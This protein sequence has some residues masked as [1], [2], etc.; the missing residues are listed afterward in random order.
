MQHFVKLEIAKAE[1]PDNVICTAV[2]D[3][4]RKERAHRF[5][6]TGDRLP[7]ADERIEAFPAQRRVRHGAVHF[8]QIGKTS[9]PAQISASRDCYRLR[10]AFGNHDEAY[11]AHFGRSRLAL[12]FAPNL[13]VS[14]D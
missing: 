1:L 2:L 6:R 8:R 5:R 10:I 3:L 12:R 13:S 9:T 7:L 14:G 11:Y 4:R